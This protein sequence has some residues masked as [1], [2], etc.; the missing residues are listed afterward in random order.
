[1]STEAALELIGSLPPDQAEVILL[2]IVADLDVA[3]TAQVTG[4]EPGHGR[5]LAHR[6][7]K[8]LRS[9]LVGTPEMSP[10]VTPTADGAV[11]N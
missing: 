6:G 10:D 8:R 4:H 2:R 1:M 5:V 9:M 11:T 7:L 3:T